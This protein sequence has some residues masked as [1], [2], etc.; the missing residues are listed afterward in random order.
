MSYRGILPLSSTLQIAE[1]HDYL[2]EIYVG[3]NAASF[4]GHAIEFHSW[5]IH[6]SNDSCSYI[7]MFV[8]KQ[9]G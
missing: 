4:I 1:A 3:G 9:L 7:M 2:F 6:S 5:F 8:M